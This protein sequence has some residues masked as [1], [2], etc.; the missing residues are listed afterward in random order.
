MEYSIMFK[1]CTFM[2]IK[3]SYWNFLL[4]SKMQKKSWNYRRK[5]FLNCTEM[6]IFLHLYNNGNF[7]TVLKWF[8]QDF[9]E[10]FVLLFLCWF[11]HKVYEYTRPLEN[12]LFDMKKSLNYPQ[13]V[14]CGQKSCWFFVF[15]M[16]RFSLFKSSFV[17]FN[18]FANSNRI[19]YRFRI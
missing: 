1:I 5:P 13:R 9:H 16:A 8:P 14:A 15:C 11:S 2:L 3:R 18:D 17:V 12:I 19:S 4:K 10:F 7:S 6:K